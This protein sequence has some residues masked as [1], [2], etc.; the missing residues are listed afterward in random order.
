MNNDVKLN[1]PEWIE[2]I[3]EGMNKQYGAYYLRS[4][5]SRRY[6]IGIL[7]V[8]AFMVAVSLLPAL[9]ASVKSSADSNLGSIDTTVELA[10]I[11]DIEEQVKE[12]NIIRETEPV[13]PPPVLKATIKFTPPVITEDENVRED[14]PMASQEE[15]NESKVQISIATV[16]GV[17][18]PDAVDIA[19]LQEHKVIVA[20]K[21]PEVYMNVE[22]MPQF[23]GGDRELLNFLHSNIRYPQ[24]ALENGIQGRVV[25]KFVVNTDGSVGDISILQGIDRTLNEEAIRVV[26]TMPKWS[27]GRQNGRAVRVFYTVPIDFRISN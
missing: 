8:V 10:D 3:F 1:S 18:D 16:D 24:I 25:L 12:E 19:E 21:E 5:S 23:P 7:A 11:K 27:P 9:I 20:E 26:K 17:D 6:V 14:E 4:T 13:A 22:Q 15:L 2:L